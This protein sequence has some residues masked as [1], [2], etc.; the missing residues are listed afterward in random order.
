MG[1]TPLNVTPFSKM[2]DD[3]FL[4]FWSSACLLDTTDIEGSVLSV[5][6]TNT[7][8]IIAIV[9]KLF[10]GEAIFGSV[11]RSRVRARKTVQIFTLPAIGTASPGKEETDV[12]VA[13]GVGA[14]EARVEFNLTAGLR[15]CFTGRVRRRF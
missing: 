11:W 5:E 9:G 2:S 8:H 6:A 1:L 13:G 7:T 10:A 4:G 14:S 12:F 3:D 15:F